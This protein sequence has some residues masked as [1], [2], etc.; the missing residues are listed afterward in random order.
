MEKKYSVKYI[1]VLYYDNKVLPVTYVRDKKGN[2]S[3][4]FLLNNAKVAIENEVTG[5]STYNRGAYNIMTL[6]TANETKRY[7]EIGTLTSA[8]INYGLVAGTKFP[9][10]YKVK[11][12]VDDKNPIDSKK[13]DQ[14]AKTY[15]NTELS[16]SEI[17]S[18][19]EELQKGYARN[20]YVCTS[21]HIK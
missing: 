21:T 20:K 10:L 16:V 9:E 5:V 1:D 15:F 8:I 17:K 18:L 6:C 19:F 3:L 7:A 12:L 11:K 14:I 2:K 13:Y 4:L